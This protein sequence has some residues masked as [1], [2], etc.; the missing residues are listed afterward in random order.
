M[1]QGRGRGGRGGRG[2]GGVFAGDDQGIADPAQGT[3]GTQAV[4]DEVV[5]GDGT[6]AAKPLHKALSSEGEASKDA[7][8][9]ICGVCERVVGDTAIG[10]DGCSDWFCPSEMCTGPV[11][12]NSGQWLGK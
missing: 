8:V 6:V 9:S 11:W 7:G 5:Q 12:P 1:A 3:D 2:R 4:A 10:F